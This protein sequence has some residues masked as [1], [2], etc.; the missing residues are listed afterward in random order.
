MCNGL[1]PVHAYCCLLCCVPWK[2]LHLPVTLTRRNCFRMDLSRVS[3]A[4]DLKEWQ[5]LFPWPEMDKYYIQYIQSICVWVCVPVCVCYCGCGMY[6]GYGYITLWIL[7]VPSREDIKPVILTSWRRFSS[8]LMEK[9]KSIKI[10][11]CSQ[12]TKHAKSRVFFGDLCVRLGLC[13]G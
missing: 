3:F 12:D 7:N 10:H 9:I 4:M 1:H 8:P 11:D 2:R 5:R 6:G 13:R